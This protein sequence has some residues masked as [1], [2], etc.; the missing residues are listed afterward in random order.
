MDQFNTAITGFFE[1]FQEI[2]KTV[3]PVCAMIG[4]IA[5]AIL[6]FGAS[7]PIISR[8][9]QNN[10]DMMANLITGFFILFVA[11]GVVSMINLG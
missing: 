7:F 11:S 5:A 3:A 1:Q 10:P 2:L 6:H 8:W 4:M 9:K